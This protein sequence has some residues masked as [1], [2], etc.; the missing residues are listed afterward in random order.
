MPTSNL[1]STPGQPESLLG[2]RWVRVWFAL[3]GVLVV[4]TPLALW[5]DLRWLA[6]AGLLVGAAIAPVAFLIA[7]E[8]RTGS[9]REAR[10]HPLLLLVAAIV[11]GS[12]AVA[13]SIALAPE[14]T[15]LGNTPYTLLVG[16]V[17]ELAKLVVP[18]LVWALRPS[19]PV[20]TKLV[21]ALLAACG[22]QV[23][24][25]VIFALGATLAVS[26]L[27]GVFVLAARGVIGLFAH[28]AWTGAIAAAWLLVPAAVAERRVARWTWRFGAFALIAALHST[29]DWSTAA[30]S[31]AVGTIT[32]LATLVAT[33]ALWR[34]TTAPLAHD[35]REIG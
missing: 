29:W 1:D 19:L 22:F 8:E 34:S 27:A 16:P 21:V 9:W 3:T 35:A 2:M 13:V 31:R 24:E 26:P 12:V 18:L 32:L 14:N 30:S 33:F 4:G 28:P 25:N 17:E 6:A 15:D 5:L 20:R 7:L 10:R 23:I 11:G